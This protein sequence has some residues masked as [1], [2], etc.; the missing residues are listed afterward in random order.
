L[1]QK[2][3]SDCNVWPHRGATVMANAGRAS[4]Y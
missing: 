1:K 2:N 3:Q 4:T